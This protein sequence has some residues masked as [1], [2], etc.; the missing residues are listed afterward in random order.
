MVIDN[1]NY[2][3]PYTQNCIL[4]KRNAENDIGIIHKNQHRYFECRIMTKKEDPM[5]QKRDFECSHI[6]LLN[7]LDAILKNS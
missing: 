4:Y 6:R 1:T 5:I 3:C 2:I 7:M